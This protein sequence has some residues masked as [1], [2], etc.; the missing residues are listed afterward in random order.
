[1]TA[2]VSGDLFVASRESHNMFPATH[3]PRQQGQGEENGGAE[4]TSDQGHC[5]VVWGQKNFRVTMF[6]ITRTARA[7][8]EFIFVFVLNNHSKIKLCLRFGSE[9][10]ANR[11]HP[12]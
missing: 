11:L 9:N 10:T 8:V 4:Q 5:Y 7:L 6:S 1:M 2:L 3:A 12:H